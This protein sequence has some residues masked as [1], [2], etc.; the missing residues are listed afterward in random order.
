MNRRSFLSSTASGLLASSIVF[1]GGALP[2]DEGGPDMLPLLHK[3]QPHANVFQ[4]P[5][6]TVRWVGNED[7]DVP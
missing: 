3:F 2:P 1:D 6:A 5:A 7:E 4:G